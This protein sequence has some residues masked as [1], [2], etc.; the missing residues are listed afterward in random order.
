MKAVS[1]D[2]NPPPKPLYAL[3]LF[4]VYILFNKKNL[5]YSNV[6]FLQILSAVFIS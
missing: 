6:L 3:H 1:E 2:T 4:A 5:L